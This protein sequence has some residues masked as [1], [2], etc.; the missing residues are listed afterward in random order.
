MQKEIKCE[1]CKNEKT[2]HLDWHYKGFFDV[3]VYKCE[4]FENKDEKVVQAVFEGKAKIETR[5]YN[6][7]EKVEK[8]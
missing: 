7:S 5:P 6:P 4:Y 2:C 8:R 3:F 1:N